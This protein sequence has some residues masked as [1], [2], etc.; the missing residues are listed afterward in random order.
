MK[1]KKCSRCKEWNEQR[2][3]Y[4]EKF[5]SAGFENAMAEGLDRNCVC[6]LMSRERPF[7]DRELLIIK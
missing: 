1:T 5:K 4:V 2:R 7:E 6:D 3:H